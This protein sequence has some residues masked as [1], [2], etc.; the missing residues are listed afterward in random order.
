MLLD[1]AL[2]IFTA[3]GLATATGVKASLLLVVIGVVFALLPDIDFILYCIL[4]PKKAFS[5]SSHEHRNTLHYPLLYIPIG[6][7]VVW[8]IFELIGH[9]GLFMSILF[10]IASLL[11]FIHDSIGIGFGV[12]WLYPFSK[13]H[14]A[15]LYRC[16][17]KD[18]GENKNWKWLYTWTFEEMKETSQQEENDHWFRD[19]YLSFHPYG[20]C[21]LIVFLLSLVVLWLYFW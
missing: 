16:S 12:L 3:L 4:H 17:L 15:F 2:G 11:H 13:T 9:S 18:T 7:I 8:S 21:E 5:R 20:M 19:I 14:Y 1:I 10:M 6:S